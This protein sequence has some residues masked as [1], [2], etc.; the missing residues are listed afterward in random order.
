[1]YVVPSMPNTT[2]LDRYC[3]I[4]GKAIFIFSLKQKEVY[5]VYCE[6]LLHLPHKKCPLYQ[7]NRELQYT[8]LLNFFLDK[9]SQISC[10]EWVIIKMIFLMN[11][12]FPITLNGRNITSK[13][14]FVSPSLSLSLSLSLCLSQVMTVMF[15]VRRTWTIQ[16]RHTQVQRE[17]WLEWSL[18][19]GM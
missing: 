1:M 11:R 3:A 8:S 10:I 13:A 19:Y 15:N 6:V 18:I 12:P 9:F 16:P 14:K 4:F 7:W 5:T 2:A 17:I